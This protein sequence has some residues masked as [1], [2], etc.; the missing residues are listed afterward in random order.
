MPA[1]KSKPELKNSFIFLI[2]GFFIRIGARSIALASEN[3]QARIFRKTRLRFRKPAEI[4]F[5][6]AARRD[7]PNVLTIFAKADFVRE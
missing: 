5:A 7:D 1:T 2:G 6:A 4:K 3:R